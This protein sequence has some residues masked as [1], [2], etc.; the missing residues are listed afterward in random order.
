MDGLVRNISMT[1]NDN[2][3]GYIRENVSYHTLCLFVQCGDRKKYPR[4]K[5]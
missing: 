4:E 3:C 2:G 1:I 5:S